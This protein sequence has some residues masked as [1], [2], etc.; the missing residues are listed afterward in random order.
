MRAIDEPEFPRRRTTPGRADDRRA[1]QARRRRGRRRSPP[2][3]SPSSNTCRRKKQLDHE[4]ESRTPSPNAAARCPRREGSGSAA[5]TY[6]TPLTVLMAHGRDRPADRLGQRRQ[7]DAGARRRARSKEVAIRL[8][9]RRRPLAADPA[10]PDREPAAG[11]VRRRAR[12]RCSR[13]GAPAPIMALFAALEAP[14]LLDVA[15]NATRASRS[16]RRSPR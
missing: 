2:S 15:P 3:M 10:V 9:R 8:V 6:A 13:S 5:P 4:D 16:R 7:P 1:S 12:L 11:A 14:V